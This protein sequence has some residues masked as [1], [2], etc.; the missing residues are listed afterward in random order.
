MNYTTYTF[1]L[2]PWSQTQARM[3]VRTSRVPINSIV[4]KS[5]KIVNGL[6]C[7]L[8]FCAALRTEVSAVLNGRRALW[9]EE[10]GQWQFRSTVLTEFPWRPH[11]AAGGTHYLLRVAR[12]AE[13]GDAGWTRRGRLRQML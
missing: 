8:Q 11:T 9:A 12:R 3:I 13:T 6:R 1:D 5:G 4:R 7:R 10:I 2:T